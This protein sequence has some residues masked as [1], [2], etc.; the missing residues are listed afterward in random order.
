MS[1]SELLIK[2]L[3]REKHC[4]FDLQYSPVTNWKIRIRIGDYGYEANAEW[5]EAAI[6]CILQQITTKRPDTEHTNLHF[7]ES[8]FFTLALRYVKMKKYYSYHTELS[9][10]WITQKW[11]LMLVFGVP[12]LIISDA[13]LDKAFEKFNEYLTCETTKMAT[14]DTM[15]QQFDRLSR[16]LIKEIPL[17]EFGQI[18]PDLVND[19]RPNFIECILNGETLYTD[20]FIFK[21]K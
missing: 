20:N 4:I 15:I 14:R 6:Y 3:S 13:K 7:L 8:K 1:P 16:E 9:Y 17:W 21:K 10:N 18:F 2:I 5:L 11:V 19:H 12:C